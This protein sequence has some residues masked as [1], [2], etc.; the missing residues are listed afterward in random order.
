MDKLRRCPKPI[1]IWIEFD[2]GDT[3]N[4]FFRQVW[5]TTTKKFGWIRS[6]VEW[7]KSYKPGVRDWKYLWLS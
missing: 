3:A 6:V 4:I 1:G 5:R 7:H 2:N